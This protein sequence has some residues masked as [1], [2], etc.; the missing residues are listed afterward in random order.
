LLAIMQSIFRSAA[1]PHLA[2][3]EKKRGAATVS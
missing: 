2:E 1:R 3:G